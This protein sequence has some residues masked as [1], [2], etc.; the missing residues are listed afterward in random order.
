M[1]DKVATAAYSLEHFYHG[2]LAS[3]SQQQGDARLLAA[4]PGVIPAHIADAL[5]HA[6]IMPAAGLAAWALVRGQ[7]SPF[8]MAQA[9]AAENGVP[10]RHYILFSSDVLRALGGN[11]QTLFTLIEPQ[12]PRFAA[13]GRSLGLIRLADVSAP[14]PAAQEEAMLGLMTFTRDRLDVIE[15]LLA[16]IIRGVTVAVR[17][18]PFDLAPRTAFIEGLLA[19]LPAPA[20]FGVTFTTHYTPGIEAQIVFCDGAAPHDLPP[21][22]VLI[23]DW[24]TA[25]VSGH[26]VEDDYSRFIKSQL[27]LDTRLVIEQTEALT[28]VAGWRIRRG[29]ALGDALKVAAR[30]LRVDHALLNHLPVQA[31]E[32]ARILAEDPTLTDSLRAVYIQHLLAFSLALDEEEENSDL[33]LIVARGNPDLE[34]AILQQMEQ[35][36]LDGRSGPV[37]RRLALW[38]DRPDGFKGMYWADLAQRAAA[39]RAQELAAQGDADGLTAFL[40]ELRANSS[41]AEMSA[42]APGLIEAALPLASDAPAL[43]RMIFMLA[44][45][46]LP[47]DRWQRI[48]T[49]GPLLSQLPAAV[50]QLLAYYTRKTPA[51]PPPGALAQACIEF[52][53]SMQPVLFIR[54]AELAVLVG[55]F[56]VFDDTALRGLAEAAASSWGDLYD[57]AI[58]WVISSLSRENVLS[59][60]DPTARPHLLA[61]LLA[62]RA[63]GELASELQRH[64][65]MLYAG[66]RQFDYA[67]LAHRLLRDSTLPPEDLLDA[68]NALAQGGVKPLPLALAHFGALERQRWRPEM[69]SAAAALTALIVENRRIAE[70]IPIDMLVE[71]LNYHVNRRDGPAARRIAALLPLLASRQGEAGAL[72]MV[73]VYR[74]LNWDKDSRA[75]A[76]NELRHFVRHCSE[77]SMPAV[78][79]LFGRELGDAIRIDLETTAV[80]Y[81]LM[82]AEHIG[83]YAYSLHTFAQFLFDTGLVYLDKTNPP[84]L[85]MLVGDLDSLNGGLSNDERQALAAAMLELG[86]LLAALAAQHRTQH[87]REED[88]YIEALLAGRGVAH[89]VLDV[90]RVMGGYFARGRRLSVRTERAINNHPLADRSAQSLLREVEQ[91]NRLIKNALHALPP[92]RALALDAGAVQRDVESLWSGISLYERRMLVRDL[93]ID[94]QRIADLTLMITERADLRA[95]RDDSSLA[96]KLD[97][98]RQRPENALEFYRFVHGYFAARVR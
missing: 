52:D 14:S 48:A 60:L 47:T 33:L 85:H 23:Y 61:A 97:A 2:P 50:S 13:A 89:S 83:D 34:R 49:H 16:A 75:S 24:K 26:R 68:L 31:S 46:H 53:P 27:R 80:I 94:L 44:A 76:L 90:F 81:R 70:L 12:M 7:A 73:S 6:S 87:A 9:A 93:A 78:T 11:L 98:N 40:G 3:E 86:R 66:D 29:D 64:G 59:A 65:R 42:S 58:R 95:L 21:E 63:Y 30:R 5:R 10:L 74:A 71:L 15:A 32:V 79:A 84:G 8:I 41:F 62:R 54:F 1:D 77:R 43:A 92:E 45:A 39:A 4:S 18:A 91:I 19:L 55:R 96:R 36:L 38:L 57:A 37:Y 72:T 25:Q 22:P 20:R 69:G 51:A 88:A 35:A 28:P 67:L 17:G 56:D 82:G